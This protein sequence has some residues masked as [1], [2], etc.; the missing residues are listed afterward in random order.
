MRRMH[1]RVWF[2]L[3]G[4]SLLAILATSIAA[5]L[6][7]PAAARH[8]ARDR[9]LAEA[10]LVG[11][12]LP[13][14]VAEATAL[15]PYLVQQ[16][17]LLK[18]Q[19]ALYDGEGVLIG[20]SR[21]DPPQ[22]HRFGRKPHWLPPHHGGRGMQIP[23]RDGRWLVMWSATPPA[24]FLP[25]RFLLVIAVFFLVL[26]G[27]SHLVA[28]RI[29][30]RLESLQ[31]GVQRFGE[32]Q[33]DARVPVEGKDEVAALA[34]R[35]N[36]AAEQ[37]GELI[38]ARR[39]ML[40]SASHELRSPLTR[41][42]MAIELM[43]EADSDK[44]AQLLASSTTDIEEL[45]ETIGDLLLA[46]RLEVQRQPQRAEAADL[47]ELLQIEAERVGA[48]V[49]G[50]AVELRGDRTALRRLLRNLL[51]NARRH[52]GGAE[53]KASLEPIAG[54]RPGARLRVADRGPGVPEAERERIFEPFYRPAGHSEGA[55]G[56]VG[57]GLSLVR[58]IAR[59]H[60]GEASCQEREGGG[61][62]FVVEIY[63]VEPTTED[64]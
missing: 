41:L 6:I 23:V 27:G 24:S 31:H 10:E 32:G 36:V 3:L 26:I 45:D 13:V 44:R 21:A 43:S 20:S 60:G 22:L 17:A 30:R 15:V 25:A 16:A 2:S 29:T 57:L 39:R 1:Q 37:I 19:L 12:N 28:R 46:S 61:T 14:G 54:S 33:L 9:Y 4:V 64:R 56:G 51:E 18:I 55:D 42:R 5:G 49:E 50:E 11:R 53:I 48:E 7:V 62:E 47:L 40:A 63:D 8:A 38:E 52:G 34:E 35:F 58:Q 59:H